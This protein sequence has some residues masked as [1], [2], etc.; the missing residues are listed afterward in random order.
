MAIVINST[1]DAGINFI[2]N[3]VVFTATMTGISSPTETRRFGYQLLDGSGVAIGPVESYLPQEGIQFSLD[4]REDLYPFVKTAYPTI[5]GALNI[6][7]E[8]VYDFKLKYWE[9]VFNKDTCTTSIVSPV[10]TAVFSMLNS[11][12]Q[13]WGSQTTGETFNLLTAYPQYYEICRDKCIQFYVYGT[14]SI[15]LT[16]YYGSVAQVQSTQAF[17]GVAVSVPVSAAVLASALD[18]NANLITSIGIEV[19]GSEYTR[20]LLKSCCSGP[21]MVYQ[22]SGGGYA[23]MFFDEEDSI[24]VQSNFTEVYTYQPK[25]TNEAPSAESRRMEGGKR[26]FNKVSNHLQTF[27]KVLT[28]DDLRDQRFYADFLSSGN[29]YLEF[30]SVAGILN[31]TTSQLA[32]FIP[33]GGNIKYFKLGDYYK[34]TIQGKVNQEQIL[35]NYAI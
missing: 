35:P 27:T 20:L 10:E 31:P 6:E 9:L 19:G 29:Y 13:Y 21:R 16:P 7:T 33:S 22:T 30:D 11:S 4:F 3:P 24:S 14:G 25:T 12:E 15:V 32:R 28:R 34:L 1:P 5:C 18:L 8:M 26:M 17:G 23:S 2:G